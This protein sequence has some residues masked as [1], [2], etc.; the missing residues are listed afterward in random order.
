M[1]HQLNNLTRQ[2]LKVTVAAYEKV[3]IQIEFV[4]G[5]RNEALM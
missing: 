5:V 1:L 4:S 3:K 2:T